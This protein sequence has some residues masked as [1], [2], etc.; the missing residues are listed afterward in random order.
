MPS[1]K[2]L[3]SRCSRAAKP[4]QEQRMLRPQSSRQ[5]RMEGVRQRRLQEPR[6]NRDNIA[7]MSAKCSTSQ[8]ERWQHKRHLGETY[9][10]PPAVL[11]RT[12]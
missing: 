4:A 3:P 2:P 7:M 12:N 11:G 1:L 9:V 8:V 6:F 5:Q 10:H